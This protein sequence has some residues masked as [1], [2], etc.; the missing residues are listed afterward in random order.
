MADTAQ[1]LA[2]RQAAIDAVTA[3]AIALDARDWAGFRA[4]FEDV[5][6]IDYGSLG[7][8]VADI[9]ARDWVD[10]CRVLGAF[11][12]T[13][14]KVSNFQV[15][16]V[17]DRAV[18]TSYVNA[19]HFIASAGEVLE[20]YALGTYVHTL[21][22]TPEGWRIAACTFRLAGHPGGRAA[23]DRAFAAARAAFAVGVQS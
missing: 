3:Y 5:I 22:R 23:F 19:A 4:L 6:Q 2:S 14:H 10:R 13:Q 8:I 16:L 7:S 11:D 1:I 17:G 21:N 15:A 20:A 18:V 12:A 9:P